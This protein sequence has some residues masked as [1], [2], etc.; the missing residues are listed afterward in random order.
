MKKKGLLLIL[1]AGCMSF[2]G[3]TAAD[4]QESRGNYEKEEDERPSEDMEESAA[5]TPTPTVKEEAQKTPTPTQAE[6]EIETS[7]IAI[8]GYTGYMDEAWEYTFRGDFV[9]TDYDL[10]GTIDRVYREHNEAAQQADYTIEFGN[11]RKINVSG[12]W[13]T[14]FPQIQAEDL[15][16]DGEKEVLFTLAYWTSTDPGSFGQMWLFEYDNKDGK[17]KEMATPLSGADPGDK[18]LDIEYGAPDGNKVSVT[19]KQNGFT[20]EAEPDDAYMEYYWLSD[21]TKDGYSESRAV[22][23]AVIEDCSSHC[24]VQVF[25]KYP[26]MIYFDLV[27]EEDGLKID[28]MEYSIEY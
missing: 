12:G 1:L 22:S 23:T 17:Y 2:A 18:Y 3:C 9:G 21:L 16:G 27:Y 24:G 5:E 19:V 28:N 20:T 26:D 13:D 10:D 25:F 15:N 11:G 7:V 14:G 4:G 6:E 8:W